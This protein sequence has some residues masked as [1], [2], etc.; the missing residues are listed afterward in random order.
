[1]TTLPEPAIGDEV[2]DEQGLFTLKW[3]RLFAQIFAALGGGTAA[4]RIV[5][6]GAPESRVTAGIGSTYHRTDGGANTTLY[7]KESGSGNTGWIAK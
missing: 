1:M 6:S 2:V 3:Y 4:Q 7:V 5:G